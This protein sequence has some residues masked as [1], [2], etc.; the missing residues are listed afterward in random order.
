M[1][2]L[3]LESKMANYTMDN[4]YEQPVLHLSK[5]GNL[6]KIIQKYYS[7]NMKSSATTTI[8]YIRAVTVYVYNSHGVE[9]QKTYDNINGSRSYI[10]YWG[11]L[12]NIKNL[13]IVHYFFSST[14]N[15]I[16][17]AHK[18][19]ISLKDF[20]TITVNIS[21]QNILTLQAG[22]TPK[23][24]SFTQYMRG[25]KILG[26]IVGISPGK[27]NLNYTATLPL[28]TIPLKIAINR[29]T[30]SKPDLTD[31]H[32]LT[33]QSGIITFS[34][35]FIS[36]TT[37]VIYISRT[38]LRAPEN[39]IKLT[40]KLTLSNQLATITPVIPTL[41][42][43]ILTAEK[44]R[45]AIDGVKYDSV[46]DSFWVHVT[47]IPS[48]LDDSIKRIYTYSSL[49]TNPT[50]RVGKNYVDR[51]EDDFY[52]IIINDNETRHVY[53]LLKQNDLLDIISPT[54]IIVRTGNF[55]EL[56]LVN[57]II[58]L[59]QLINIFATEV[60][61]TSITFRMQDNLLLSDKIDSLQLS[62]LI[63]STQ[64]NHEIINN[65]QHNY[66]EFTFP[67]LTAETLYTFSLKAKIGDI[68]EDITT[69]DIR[70][71]MS[72]SSNSSDLEKQKQAV[73][74]ILC[75]SLPDKKAMEVMLLP[76]DNQIKVVENIISYKTIVD[77]L[78][79]GVDRNKNN[80]SHK[81]GKKPEATEYSSEINIIAKDLVAAE[82][83]IIPEPHENTDLIQEPY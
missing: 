52:Q 46:K 20:D 82:I 72:I 17:R 61:D 36:K 74:K 16:T 65:Q 59:V 58:P 35:S 41:T 67:G 55:V 66:L 31:Y 53:V 83:L 64:T 29:G 76:F 21:A 42:T 33:S 34:A 4:A 45:I 54:V 7:Q 18:Y 12:N 80:Y 62:T 79:F 9:E 68:Y 49:I 37:A 44:V 22:T 69:V 47:F 23:S 75:E 30:E 24:E 3:E 32:K 60:S 57:K 5:V 26:D 8:A 1:L 77:G 25:N 56:S 19:L 38:Y 39:I 81:Y 48:N 63:G 70:T 71:V 50:N 13:Q 6:T 73:A 43:P 27:F 10:V 14:I 11:S 78:Y 15:L 2:L 40:V 51:T 28:S